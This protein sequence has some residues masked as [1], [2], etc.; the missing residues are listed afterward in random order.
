[1][2]LVSTALV[3]MAIAV[4]LMLLPN[5]RANSMTFVASPCWA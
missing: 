4:I 5:V 1:M 2:R 3:M